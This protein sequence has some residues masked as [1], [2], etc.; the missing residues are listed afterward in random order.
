MRNIIL[1]AVL[2][3]C[4]AC[5]ES[6][7]NVEVSVHTNALVG[8]SEHYSIRIKALDDVVT[9]SSI[10]LNR[11]NCKITELKTKKN[12]ELPITLKFG[13]SKEIFFYPPCEVI[14]AELETNSGSWAFSF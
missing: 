3:I 14:E 9:I 7:P 10:V 13:E 11:G 8:G 6:Q 4:T 5:G 1:V 12:P 2:A